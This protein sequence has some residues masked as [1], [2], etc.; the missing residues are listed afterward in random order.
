[1]AEKPLAALLGRDARYSGDLTFD[2]RVRVD[3]TFTG[4]ISTDDVLEVGEPGRVDGQ[5]D[6]H[7]LIVSGIVDGEVRCRGVLVITATGTVR[8]KVDAA[9]MEVEPG[10]HLDAVVR[11]G[12]T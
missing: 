6:A 7:T 10:A 4:R 11:V 3:G 12:V 8:G 1:M 9:Q 5:I 2:G